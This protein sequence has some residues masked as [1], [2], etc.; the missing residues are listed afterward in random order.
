MALGRNP[1]LDDFLT[2]SSIILG[3]AVL[4]VA[5]YASREMQK[6]NRTMDDIGVTD[7]PV[8]DFPQLARV[9]WLELGHSNPNVLE[10]VLKDV[11]RSKALQE[12]AQQF[13]VQILQSAAVQAALHHLVKQVWTDLIQDPETL[14]QIIH[15]LHVAIQDPAV[16]TAAQRLVVDLVQDPAVQQ[17]LIR[18]IQQLGQAREVQQATQGLLVHSAHRSLND[19]EL[20]EHSME[21]AT[22]VLGDDVVQQT[23]G[24]A[25]RNT[26]G[27]A[28]RPAAT[29]VTTAT[30]ISLI[31]FGLIAL[32]FARSSDQEVRVLEQAALSLQTNAVFGLMRL[33][34]WP[35]TQVQALLSALVDAILYTPL[36]ESLQTLL[37]TLY[38]LPEYTAQT[39]VC[40][41]VQGAAWVG[42][43]VQ[44]MGYRLV[45][46]LVQLVQR[47]PSALATVLAHFGRT[48]WQ[49]V[50]SRSSS[51]SS[52]RG[53]STATPS[54][55]HEGRGGDQ[56]LPAWMVGGGQVLWQSLITVQQ[57]CTTW[58]HHAQSNL[59]Q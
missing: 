3:F 14:T 36:I 38:H 34:K 25:L 51:S 9:E 27:H 44:H 47:A 15:V 6:S 22:D 59:R 42:R 37:E 40:W 49:T 18:V 54:S 56:M 39:A 55:S 16:K 19:A 57:A 43:T 28:V 48:V 13:V 41:L 12:A 52:N 11:V 33:V 10:D 53:G 1:H 17:S 35:I 8:D 5:P 23:A 2:V 46:S 45:Q 24:E 4:A 26:V 20:L 29:V 58:W 31:L 30:G 21:F 7:D 32:A 50:V